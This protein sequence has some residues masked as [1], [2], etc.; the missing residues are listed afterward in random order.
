MASRKYQKDGPAG[1]SDREGRLSD[2]LLLGPAGIPGGGQGDG[3]QA[4]ARCAG[5][6]A[7][8]LLDEVCVREHAAVPPPACPPT[9]CRHSRHA[10][11]SVTLCPLCLRTRQPRLFPQDN[12]VQ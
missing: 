12:A 4:A 7:A 5:L 1:L 6:H 2:V 9:S 8:A 10:S 11:W 3:Q